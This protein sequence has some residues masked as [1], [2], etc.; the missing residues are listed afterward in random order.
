MLSNEQWVKAMKAIGVPTD[1]GNYLSD[2]QYR[3]FQIS[4]EGAAEAYLAMGPDVKEFYPGGWLL[5]PRAA[6][7]AIWFEIIT[8]K[9]QV[10]AR[11]MEAQSLRDRFIRETNASIE[12]LKRRVSLQNKPNL[13]IPPWLK[14]YRVECWCD[15]ALPSALEID[16]WAKKELVKTLP[17][18]LVDLL[19]WELARRIVVLPTTA[20]EVVGIPCIHWRFRISVLVEATISIIGTEFTKEFNGHKYGMKLARE[21]PGVLYVGPVVWSTEEGFLTPTRLLSFLAKGELEAPG[22]EV[23]DRSPPVTRFCIDGF[24]GET[25]EVRDDFRNFIAGMSA[26]GNLWDNLLSIHLIDKLAA[27]LIT[28]KEIPAPVAVLGQSSGTQSADNNGDVASALQDMGYKKDEVEKAIETAKLLHGMAFE[29]K[30]KAVVKK[31]DAPP[32]G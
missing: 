14:G 18:Q 31:L 29:E 17:G 26:K 15:I 1:A 5:D 8:N 32:S 2:R 6:Q 21:N 13:D 16:L 23:V 27:S 11:Y 24:D 12:Q 10:E 22:I 4:L 30:L 3:Q 25:V 7:Y 19:S 9:K 28:A 20:Y